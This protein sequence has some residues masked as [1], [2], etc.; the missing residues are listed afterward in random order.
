MSAESRQPWPEEGF[1]RPEEI[2]LPF[3]LDPVLHALVR[4]PT[5]HQYAVVTIFESERD[6]KTFL[7]EQASRTFLPEGIVLWHLA[8]TRDDL[9]QIR[10]DRGLRLRPLLFEAVQALEGAETFPAQRIVPLRVAALG[11]FLSPDGYFLTNYHVMGE[12]IEAAGHTEGSSEPLTCRFTAFELPVVA[13]RRITTWAS[14]QPVHLLRHLS[15]QDWKAGFDAALLQAG[16]CPGAHLRLANRMPEL[17]EEVWV[18][19]LP[20]RSGRAVERRRACGYDD[21]DGTLRVSRGRVTAI[22]GDHNFITDAD[23]FNGY[24]GGPV[25]TQD[26]TVLGMNWNVYP[27]T[28]VDRRAVRFEGGSIHV[29]AAAI[30]DRL[31]SPLL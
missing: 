22:Q 31:L 21:A 29:T 11:F 26:G 24:S 30:V 1:Y 5:L 20:V 28:E 14:I 27:A 9:D 17:G 25:L 15:R 18:F 6:K 2:D 23:S 8:L 12:E 13:D 16:K 4:I 7:P 19:G 10:A 3:D